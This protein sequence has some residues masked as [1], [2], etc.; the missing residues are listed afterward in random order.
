MLSI[1]LLNYYRQLSQH[2][3]T[4]VDVETTGR[5]PNN[6]R[7][8]E[9]SVLQASLTDGIHQQQTYLINPQTRIPAKITQFT[10]ISQAMVATA[11]VAAEVFPACFPL[12]NAGILTAHNIDFDYPFL[13]A[14]YNRLN[15]Q[16][17]R[18]AHEQLCTVQLSRLMLPD[19]PSRRLPNLVQHFHFQVGKS[20]RAEADTLAC[21]LLAER[22]FTELLN[23]ADEKLLSRF[24]RQWIPLKVAAKLLGCTSNEARSRLS[25]AAVSSR[26]AGRSQRGTMMYRRGDVERLI[27]QP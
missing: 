2:L 22:L 13:Q 7:V 23:E 5:Y 4:V 8:I 20:H 25:A 17:D 15:I 18:P 10:G 27:N 3:F 19:L 9:I 6:H 24:A 11:P 14:E 21:W 16:F 1:D 12:L 26:F